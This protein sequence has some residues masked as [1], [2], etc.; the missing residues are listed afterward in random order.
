MDRRSF[1][2]NNGGILVAVSAPALTAS[3]LAKAS[4]QQ[5]PFSLIN[6]PTEKFSENDWITIAAVQNHLFPSDNKAPGAVEIN[7][8]RY[9]HNFLSNPATD[10][11]EI[12]FIL[13]GVHLLQNFIQGYHFNDNKANK[14]TSFTD[15]SIEQREILLREFEKKSDGKRW[16]VNILNYVLESLLTDPI[17]SGNPNGIGWQWLEHRAGE[18]RPPANKRYW[19]M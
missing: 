4:M 8:L 18:P 9:L 10:P 7:A 15:L 14:K 2:V 1:I 12:E 5:Q 13:E 11:S 16:L 6:N 19:L 3:S 17:Y